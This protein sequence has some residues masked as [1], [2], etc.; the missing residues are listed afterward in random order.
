MSYYLLADGRCLGVI[1]T[2]QREG[3][4]YLD[5]LAGIMFVPAVAPVSAQIADLPQRRIDAPTTSAVA[6]ELF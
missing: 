2:N 6:L 3:L 4:S 1:D 5:H